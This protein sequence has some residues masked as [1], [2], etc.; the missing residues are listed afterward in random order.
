MKP[1][2]CEDLHRVNRS[3]S[4][5]SHLASRVSSPSPRRAQS[6]FSSLQS[7]I[8]SFVIGHLSFAIFL[9][10][11][12]L[13]TVTLLP[14]VLPADSGEFQRVA[15]TAGVAHPPGFPLYTMLGWLFANLPLGPTPAWRANLFSAVTAAAT[16][17]LVFRIGRR[18][19]GS[20]WGGLAAALTLGSATTFWATATKASIRPLTAFF[21]ALCFDAL[22]LHASRL[23][24]YVSRFASDRHLI[25]FAMALSFGLTHHPSLVFP[26]S[27]FIA[28]L[29]V[30]DPALVRKPRR[31]LKPV[32]AFA[33]GLLVLIYLPLRGG[34]DLATPSGFLNYVL[35]RGFRG[36]MFALDLLDRLVLLPTL[37]RFQFNT[38]L[39]LTAFAGALLLLWRDRK[40]A[41]L[42]IGSFVIHT[43]VTL[44][45]DAPQTVEYELPAYVSLAL[46]VAV[47]FGEISNLKSL[48]SNLKPPGRLILFT[49]HCSL[50]I[51]I[52][53]G[54]A[55]LAVH[56]PSY[57]KLSQG[58][59]ARAYAELLLREAPE[60]AV[61]LSNWHWFTPMRYLQRVEG[62]RPDVTVEYVY[63]RGEPLAQTWVSTIEAFAPQRAVVVTRYFEQEYG[64]LAY[65]FEPLT[66]GPT[67]EAFLVRAEPNFT[68]PPELT[69]RDVT[70]GEQ[71]KVIG[72]QLETTEVRPARPLELTLAWSPVVTPTIDVALFAQ[73]IGPEGQLWSAAQDSRHSA[74]RLVAGEVVVE[75][76]AVYP[77]LHALPGEYSLV[78]GAYLPGEQGAPRLNT[79]DGTDAV[80]LS[81][82]C[83]QPATTRP[84]TNHPRFVHF[85]GGPTL[86]GVD[87]DINASGQVR[88]YLH[89]AGPGDAARLTL[90]GRDDA[91]LSASRVPRLERG[92]YATLAFD[93]PSAAGR[94]S[95]LGEDGPRRWNLVFTGSVS[96]P[97]PQ[98]GERYVPFGD[99]MV[100]TGLDRPIGDL[101][102]GAEVTLGLRFRSQ[103]PLERDY[104]VSTALTG[105]NPDGT[106]AWRD[107]HDGV[108]ALG[109][110]PTLKWIHGS[111]VFDPHHITV[112]AES[113]SVPVVG[114]LVVYDHFTQASLPNL[115]ERLGPNVPLGSWSLAP[116]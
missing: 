24:F 43:V 51:L 40:L 41:L 32:T 17:A 85:A 49:V 93:R 47:P 82:I 58:R 83:V 61:I 29:I 27:A 23:T 25:T 109:A 26:A 116:P 35:A 62:L 20:V 103:R 69:R 84:V 79:S 37:L 31:W 44:T 91:F 30:I 6:P 74:S 92:Q 15:A 16:V 108:P 71:I 57:Q 21:A 72:Y 78:V 50:F 9:I 12:A 114:S 42:L 77:L 94:L 19:T 65:R 5:L 88:T 4:C 106:W 96:L 28:Y 115:D 68:P 55:N 89:W 39:L 112:P 104:V 76:F 110:I 86:I 98:S 63:P 101:E 14:D 56:L 11:L 13:Y 73:L 90:A 18:L 3:S 22:T 67:G 59:D 48:I 54:I 111:T 87:Y 97:A 75:R 53:A 80:H 1:E 99:A 102:P 38:V 45:Y 33:L 36:D 113:P 46:L 107:P 95:L 70:L 2:S 66:R 52:I 60:D 7:A 10:F 64:A 105:L 100:L 81:T 8:P 34:S